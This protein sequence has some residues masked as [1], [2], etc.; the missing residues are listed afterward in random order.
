MGCAA[1][2]YD[3]CDE[4]WG[5]GDADRHWPNL[6]AYEA[7]RRAWEAEQCAK[8]LAANTGCELK[9]FRGCLSAVVGVIEK[10]ARRRKPPDGKDAFWYA[11]AAEQ[12][13]VAMR[14]LIGEEDDD[15]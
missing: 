3:Q 7:S 1:M 12:V 2:T 14:R 5:S 4:C 10:E 15:V 9:L 8:W 6:R 11:R 13:A